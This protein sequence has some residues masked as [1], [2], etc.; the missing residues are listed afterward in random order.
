MARAVE[1]KPVTPCLLLDVERMT[2]N[3]QVLEAKLDRL[4]V[5]VRPHVKTC[6][7]IDIAH[8]MMG[9]AS[10]GIA[11]STL[12]EAEY[13]LDH[14]IAD[15]IYAV[16]IAPGK[17]ERVAQLAARGADLKILL[18]NRKA[19]AA[20][21]EAARTHD[22]RYRVLLEID[23]DGHRAGFRPRDAD[24]IETARAVSRAGCDIAGV[25][26]HM[27]ASYDCRTRKCLNDAAEKE[28]TSAVR[29][30][31]RLRAAG[32]ECPIV[33][34]GSTPTAFHARK[35]DG[36]T[37]VRA[38]THVFMDLVMAGLGVCRLEDIA[39]SVLAEIIGFREGAGELVV[40]AG[41]MALSRDRG[42]AS[43]RVDQ[44]YGV[45]CD[46]AGRPLEDDLIVR[47]T[48][49][50]HGL[51]ARRDGAP[52]DI[53]RFGIGQ[54]LRILPNHACATAAQHAGYWLLDDAGKPARWWP[55]I[56]GW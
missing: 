22:C 35:L 52:I 11:V 49:Q 38:G 12:A 43:Q 37:E 18:D 21:A 47:S 7:N 40:D 41:W 13:F 54:Q 8:R 17:L 16:G 5:P 24:L 48:N 36:V 10:P 28:R 26:T 51:V 45:V 53:D 44:G 34:V 27:G 1:H 55:R 30:A 15:Q 23:S 3:I 6:K 50:E 33:S 46:P 56:G 19:A 29:A 20:V 42:T 9:P 31:E 2:R 14:G 25:L 4:R 39:I 32:I